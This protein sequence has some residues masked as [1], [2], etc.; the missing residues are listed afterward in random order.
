MRRYSSSIEID[1]PVERVFDFVITPTNLP[2]VWPSMID[3]SNVKRAQDGRYSFDWTYK[4]VGVPFKGHSE[5]LEYTPSTLSFVRNAGG[6]P[7]T[8]RWTFTKKGAG[9]LLAVDVEYEIPTP[10]IGKLAESLVAKMNEREMAHVLENMKAVTEAT[11]QK[12]APKD[13]HARH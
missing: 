10:M 12:G 8:F 6:I 4:M 7:S 3:V 1:A 2:G 9:T 11:M 13:V 5:T